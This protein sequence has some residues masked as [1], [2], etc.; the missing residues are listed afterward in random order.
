MITTRILF[1]NKDTDIT[2]FD[3]F[4]A[5]GLSLVMS[6]RN[7]FVEDLKFS[8]KQGWIKNLHS[9]EWNNESKSAIY[10][11]YSDDLH[12]SRYFQNYIASKDYFSVGSST[13]RGI[14][15]TVTV[16]TVP[17]NLVIPF[18]DAQRIFDQDVEVLV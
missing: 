18:V 2:N 12:Q 9:Q 1:N 4:T 5:F 10:E 17:K 14:G 3:D 16:E 13:L 7:S 8:I 6:P 15:W 11:Y